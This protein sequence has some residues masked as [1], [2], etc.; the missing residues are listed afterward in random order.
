MFIKAESGVK[1]QNDDRPRLSGQNRFSVNCR[2]VFI[3]MHNLPNIMII[4][5]QHRHNGNGRQS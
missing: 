4:R 3:H 1:L 2:I 5:K